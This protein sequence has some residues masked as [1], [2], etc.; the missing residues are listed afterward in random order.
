MDIHFIAVHV[1]QLQ[2]PY[3]LE[4]KEGKNIPVN[5]LHWASSMEICILEGMIRWLILL[6]SKWQLDYERL[7]CY[8]IFPHV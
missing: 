2:W 4:W 7:G 1:L 8:I 6:L 5:R 3:S